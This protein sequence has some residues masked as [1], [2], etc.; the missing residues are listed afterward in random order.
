MPAGAIPIRRAVR[1]W[2]VM[3][4]VIWLAAGLCPV[5]H[6]AAAAAGMARSRDSF[7]GPGSPVTAYVVNTGSGTVTPISTATNTAGPP[8]PVGAGPKDIAITPDGKTAYVTNLGSGTVTPIT[9]AT[10]TPGPPIPVGSGPEDIAITPDGKTVY[11]IDYLSDMV[12]PIST[13][14]NTAGPP[15][16]VGNGD[17]DIAITPDGKTAYITNQT[18]GHGDPDRDRHQHPWPADP[19]RQRAQ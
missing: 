7:L 10:K 11:V 17:Q 16:S 1:R 6:A 19:G 13:V 9:I 8:I 4:V 15:I 18:F 3:P 5:A 14:T 2:L 12:T